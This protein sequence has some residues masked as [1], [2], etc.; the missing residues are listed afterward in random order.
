MKNGID[1]Y[2]HA[3]P[4]LARQQN[5]E[6]PLSNQMTMFLPSKR[7]VALEKAVLLLKLPRVFGTN[8]MR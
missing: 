8:T 4:T 7:P 6:L 3:Q 1:I 2:N 5:R